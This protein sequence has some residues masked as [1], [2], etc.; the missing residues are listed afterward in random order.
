L[1]FNIDFLPAMMAE[2]INK[3]DNVL[4]KEITNERVRG[5]SNS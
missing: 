3:M 1:F 5:G 4:I 2:V